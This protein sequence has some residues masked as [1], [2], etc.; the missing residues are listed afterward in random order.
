MLV[1]TQVPH[2]ILLLDCLQT[3]LG[4][5]DKFISITSLDTSFGVLITTWGGDVEKLK[6]CEESLIT[7]E[8]IVMTAYCTPAGSL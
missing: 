1:G 2:R 3:R 6:N 8:Y 4:M 7:P 5:D